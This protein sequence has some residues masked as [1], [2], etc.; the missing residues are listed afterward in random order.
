M[1]IPRSTYLRI[2]RMGFDEAM[3]RFIPISERVPLEKKVEQD[4]RSW[5]QKAGWF[6]IKIMRAS[7]DGFPD[8]FYARS[9]DQD[10]CPY[11]GRGRVVLIEWKRKGKD[12]SPIQEQRINELREAGVEVYVVRDLKEARRILGG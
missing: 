8:R 9:H 12:L 3:R 1:M 5:A 10:R 7:L 2:R 11:C 4:N 6:V